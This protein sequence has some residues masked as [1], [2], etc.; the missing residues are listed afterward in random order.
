MAVPHLARLLAGIALVALVG[1]CDSAPITP[2][3]PP[4]SPPSPSSLSV[5][6]RV[7]ALPDGRPVAGTRL[8]ARLQ[9]P[10]GWSSLPVVTADADGRFAIRDF[11]NP[12]LPPESLR[13]AT[14]AGARSF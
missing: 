13:Q 5:S 6:G 14:A 3:P 2:T 10:W 11:G 8:I 1:G 4:V 7:E 9:G 12:F